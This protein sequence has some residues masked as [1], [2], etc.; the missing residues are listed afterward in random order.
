[1]DKLKN[2]IRNKATGWILFASGM[3]L[4]EVSYILDIRI[5]HVLGGI[6]WPIGMGL[7]TNSMIRCRNEKQESQTEDV[8]GKANDSDR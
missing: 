8:L 7:I 6:L 1:M 3:L 5:I 4:Q 2:L